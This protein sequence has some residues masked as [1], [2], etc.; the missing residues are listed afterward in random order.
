MPASVDWAGY[1]DFSG[2]SSSLASRIGPPRAKA[3]RK[4]T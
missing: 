1:I 4:K 2:A 3:V